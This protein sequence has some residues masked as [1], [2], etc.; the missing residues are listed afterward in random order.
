MSGLFLERLVAQ[1][2]TTYPKQQP[3]CRDFKPDALNKWNTF[4]NTTF[5]KT[6]LD[7]LSCFGIEDTNEHT[8]SKHLVIY[9][10]EFIDVRDQKFKD[11][12]TRTWVGKQIHISV[13][14]LLTKP[15]AKTISVCSS[16]LYHFVISFIAVLGK[17]A[18]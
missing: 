16:D 13:S 3:N 7:T 1:L 15:D 12:D 4:L 17:K 5:L 10:F 8:F 18:V 6:L 9:I 11:N 2:T 14:N